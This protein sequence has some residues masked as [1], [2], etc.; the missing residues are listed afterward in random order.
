MNKHLLVV[1]TAVGIV[2]LIP[3]LK[4]FRIREVDAYLGRLKLKLQG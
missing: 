2:I 3:L 1:A 4:L